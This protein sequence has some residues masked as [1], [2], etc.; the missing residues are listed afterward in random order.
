MPRKNNA[1]KIETMMLT[2]ARWFEAVREGGVEH[3][4][5]LYPPPMPYTVTPRPHGRKLERAR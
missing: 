3:A 5:T 4:N 1:Y 2:N